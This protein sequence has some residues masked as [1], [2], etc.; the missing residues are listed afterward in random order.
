VGQ[1]LEDIVTI[2]RLLPTSEICYGFVSLIRFKMETTPTDSHEGT[3]ETATPSKLQGAKLA[4]KDAR[5]QLERAERDVRKAK[6]AVKAA[7]KESK[8][9]K[10]K[11][12][13]KEG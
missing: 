4:L 2:Q 10:K 8:L 9:A 5:E 1:C 3:P 13:K 12:K 7:R 11:R 6:K